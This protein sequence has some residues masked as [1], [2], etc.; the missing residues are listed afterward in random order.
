MVLDPDNIRALGSSGHIF[1]LRAD[2]VEIYGKVK[3]SPH[4]PLLNVEDPVGRIRQLLVERESF[5]L[6]ADFQVDTTGLSPLETANEIRR[7]LD[8]HGTR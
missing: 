5:Y 8:A 2:P 7:M 3:D 4:R 1:C 6:K